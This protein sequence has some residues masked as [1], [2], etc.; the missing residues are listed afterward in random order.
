M[1]KPS[2]AISDLPVHFARLSSFLGCLIFV[3]VVKTRGYVH[4]VVVDM[5]L[6]FLSCFKDFVLIWTI[7]RSEPLNHVFSVSSNGFW[8][9]QKPFLFVGPYLIQRLYIL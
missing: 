3:H 7:Q 8:F 5:V 9:A 6:S 4:V 1:F 2:I